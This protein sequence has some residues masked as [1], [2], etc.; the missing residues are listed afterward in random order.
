MRVPAV[1]LGVIGAGA[2]PYAAL[3]V[4]VYPDS[5]VRTGLAVLTPLVVLIAFAGAWRRSRCPRCGA[6]KSFQERVDGLP[7]A[8]VGS[9]AGRTG[10]GVTV[11]L[12]WDVE[13]SESVTCVRCAHEYETRAVAFVSRGEARSASEAVVV[14]R[15]QRL[16]KT[17]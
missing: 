3:L 12:G 2:L 11:E 10:D 16:G 14:A 1:V 13:L 7:V 17:R 5:G 15:Q 4:V 8:T 6:R 9:R